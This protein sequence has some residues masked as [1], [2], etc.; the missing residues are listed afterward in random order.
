VVI[1]GAGLAG[2]RAAETL[3]SEGYDGRVTLVGAEQHPPYDRPPLSKDVLVG[4]RSADTHLRTPEQLAALD[5]DLRLGRPA[6]ELDLRE[7]SLVLGS[8][9]LEFEGLILA[10][11]AAPRAL[12]LLAGRPGVF[13]LRTPADA[14][15]LRAAFESAQHVVVVG[16]GFIGSEVAASARAVG[17]AVTIVELE[18]TPLARVLGGEMGA[19]LSD[20]H[21]RNG[22]ELIL[23]ETIVEVGGDEPLQLRLTS[24]R[25][26]E[27]DVVV[28][29]IGVVPDTGWLEGSGLQLENGVVCDASLNAGVAGVYAAGDVASWENTLFRQ[30]MRVEHWTNAAE[31]GRHAALELLHGRGAPF[32]GSNYVWSDQYGTRIQTI[33]SLQADECVVVDGD[34]DDLRFV[35]WYRRG[36][37]LVGALGVASA[38]LLLRS[39]GLIEARTRWS[40]A[41]EAL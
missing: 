3:R 40:D 33:G 26:L 12:P 30:R 38:K 21:R 41:I 31:Q 1:V 25:V 13:T 27:A 17:A 10:T 11:G 32:C 19:A 4:M 20:L 18:K 29:G 16:A 15:G 28:V 14:R 24:G 37:R 34:V 23:G 2:L 8:A 7:R 39:R 22:T 36:E 5:L 6:Q 35:A 9:R